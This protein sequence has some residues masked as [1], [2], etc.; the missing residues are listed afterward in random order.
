MH[1]A[2]I[3]LIIF[4]FHPPKQFFLKKGKFKGGDRLYFC[5]FC[6][7]LKH[8]LIV[9]LPKTNKIAA[10]DSSSSLVKVDGRFSVGLSKESIRKACSFT[11]S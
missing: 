1:D 4:G 3:K 6:L 5:R 2:L 8:I 7:A 11:L 10:P 9:S